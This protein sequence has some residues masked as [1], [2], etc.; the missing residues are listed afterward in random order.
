MFY[1]GGS[2]KKLGKR[3][4]KHVRYVKNFGRKSVIAYHYLSS[5]FSFNFNNISI[6]NRD[7]NLYNRR[8]LE[9]LNIHY[10]KNIIK[11]KN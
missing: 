4:S 6:L 3:V 1:I 7:M 10:Y 11:K 2:K 8:S 9:I 5:E